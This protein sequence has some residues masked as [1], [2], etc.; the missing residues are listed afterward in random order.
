MVAPLQQVWVI[1]DFLQLAGKSR[2]AAVASVLVDS[3]QRRC[4]GDKAKLHFESA[5]TA[6]HVQLPLHCSCCCWPLLEQDTEWLPL[7]HCRCTR[8]RRESMLCCVTVHF[9]EPA[10]AYKA[11]QVLPPS[12]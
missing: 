8:W 11:D 3:T 4:A 1:L 5:S 2:L 10:K 9:R 6:Q 12:A 7:V